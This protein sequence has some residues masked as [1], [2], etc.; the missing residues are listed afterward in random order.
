MSTLRNALRRPPGVLPRV[1]APAARLDSSDGSPPWGVATPDPVVSRRLGLGGSAGSGGRGRGGNRGHPRRSR[2]RGRQPNRGHRQSDGRDQRRHRPVDRDD[3][4]DDGRNRNDDRHDHRSSVSSGQSRPVMACRPERLHRR[5]QLD[6]HD[7]RP[8]AS[9]GGSKAG[10]S[11][12]LAGRRRARIVRLLDPPPRVL[13]RLLRLLS[14]LGG[15]DQRRGRSARRR[16]P[17]PVPK[18][19]RAVRCSGAHF[20]QRIGRRP[21]ATR[22]S[23]YK[24]DKTKPDFVTTLRSG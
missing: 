1:R 7:C 4:T 18:A 13:R 21:F 11:G 20:G 19:D 17:C 24:S 3:P 6:T 10:D 15:G 9:D 2:E 23:V 22:C 14:G 8:C 5:A 12:R 16:I